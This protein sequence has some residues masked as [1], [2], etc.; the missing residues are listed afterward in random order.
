MEKH[1]VVAGGFIKT[2]QDLAPL[3]RDDR[4][5]VVRAGEIAERLQRFPQQ[6]RYEL[7]FCISLTPQKI[8]PQVSFHAAD[9]GQY[10][11]L[12][13]CFIGLSLLGFRVPVLDSCNH[14]GPSFWSWIGSEEIPIVASGRLVRPSSGEPQPERNRSKSRCSA[15]SNRRNEFP[16]STY[17][18]I[19][20]I[21]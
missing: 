19:R 12:E 20:T 17:M 6:D 8:A 9:S 15:N 1:L 14:L 4:C 3:R 16:S 2:G 18:D 5:F 21:R 13:H 11:R 7:H 10:F